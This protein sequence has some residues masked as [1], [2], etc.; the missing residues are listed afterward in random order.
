MRHIANVIDQC[1]DGNKRTRTLRQIEGITV[2]MIDVGKN[3]AEICGFLKNYPKIRGMSYTFVVNEHG[4]IEQAKPL[5]AIT[6]HAKNHNTATLGIACIGDFRVKE[7]PQ[8]QWQAC[9]DLCAFIS[10]YVN[11]ISVNEIRG[12]DERPNSSDD[13][14]KHC[15][16]RRWEMSRFRTAV[17]QRMRTVSMAELM[18]AGIAI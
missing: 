2:H 9:V 5:T 15:P 18:I 12:H 4:Y 1:E 8:E 14:D 13:P 16:G 10:F 11:R 6:P 17:S 3:A 7:P